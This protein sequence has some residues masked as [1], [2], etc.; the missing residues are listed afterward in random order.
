VEDFVHPTD[1]R[2]V[3]LAPDMAQH[4]QLFFF[5]YFAMTGMHALHMVIGISILSFCST[6]PGMCL[7]ERA[8]FDHR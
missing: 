1:K 4:A 8:Y 2:D 5:L 6:R 7:H 3:P